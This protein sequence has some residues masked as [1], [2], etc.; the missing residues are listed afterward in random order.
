MD[1]QLLKV[2]ILYLWVD[3]SDAEWQQKCCG[4]A[5]KKSIPFL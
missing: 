4:C 3:G 1:K 2:D 5:L